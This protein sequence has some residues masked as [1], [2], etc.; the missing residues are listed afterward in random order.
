MATRRGMFQGLFGGLMASVMKP[1]PTLK[2]AKFQQFR[3][4]LDL[5]PIHEAAADLRKAA[6]SMRAV[7]DA[8]RM[9]KLGFDSQD[10]DAIHADQAVQRGYW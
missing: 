6:E 3:M 8:S 7:G 4:N 9:V 1:T 2:P 5:S 10:P